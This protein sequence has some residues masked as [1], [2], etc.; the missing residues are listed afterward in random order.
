M[1]VYNIAEC[2]EV[3][4]LSHTANNAERGIIFCEKYNTRP[5]K[6]NSMF[7]I[8]MNA[9]ITWKA[10]GNSNKYVAIKIN[11]KKRTMLIKR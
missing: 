11:N 3:G 8:K 4:K 1:I 6:H 9:Y 7:L 2:F 10:K 5:C